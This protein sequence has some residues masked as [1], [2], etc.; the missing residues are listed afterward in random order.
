MSEQRK[1]FMAESAMPL[2]AELITDSLASA[3]LSCFGAIFDPASE[4]FLDDDITLTLL[5]CRT[6][7]FVALGRSDF[8]LLEYRCENGDLDGIETLG[9]FSLAEVELLLT[10]LVEVLRERAQR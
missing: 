2:S 5:G 4:P 3:G 9:K 8:K 7:I 10:R 6:P 1:L